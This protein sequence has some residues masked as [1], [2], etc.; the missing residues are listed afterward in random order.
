MTRATDL[1]SGLGQ[2]SA[3]CWWRSA[4]WNSAFGP[5][6]RCGP[7]RRSRTWRNVS[8]C[9]GRPCT[10]GWPGIA[11]MGLPGWRIDPAVLVARRGRRRPRWKRSFVSCAEPIH[12]GVP[13]GSCSN[14]AGGELKPEPA[15]VVVEIHQQVPGRL[16]HPGAGGVC[17]DPGQMHPAAVEFDDEEDVE[18]GQ[19]DRLDGQEVAGEGAGGLS[20]QELRPTG[21][22][23]RGAGPRWWRR[24]MVR[25]EVAETR[26]PSLLHSPTIRSYPQRGFSRARRAARPA[27]SGSNARGCRASVG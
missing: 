22:P 20:A 19:P 25:T 5:S 11:T 3:E 6:W 9:A 2:H 4:W 10:N 14:S 23:R 16:R 21:P 8:A 7:G 27:I 17:G 24:R 1:V 26:T 12:G 15:G 13:A 18:A